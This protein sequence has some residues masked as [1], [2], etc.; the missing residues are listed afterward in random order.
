MKKIKTKYRRMV[1][2]IP[3]PDSIAFF[4]SL[5]AK[6]CRSTHEQPPVIWDKAYG[7]QVFDPFGNIFLDF[8]SGVL[9]ANCGHS[10]P[11]VVRAIRREVDRGL[12]HSYCFANAARERLLRKLREISPPELSR[13]YLLSTGSETIET[14]IKLCRQWG[15]AKSNN[16]KIKIIS[17]ENNFHGRTLGAQQSGGIKPL[18]DWIV[19]LDK[20]FIQVPFPDGI[21]CTDT[22]FDV[23]LTSLQ[24]KGVDPADVAGVLVETY[25]GGIVSFA[26]KEYMQA[27]RNWCNKH[28]ILLLFDEVQAGFGRTGKWWGFQH[29]EIVP[30][31][32]ACGKGI[33]G[34]LP[35]SAVIGRNTIMQQFDAGAMTTT[36]GGN[37]ICCAAAAASIEVL[38]KEKLVKNAQTMGKLLARELDKIFV[39]ASDRIRAVCSHG[40]VAGIHIKKENSDEPDGELAKKIV[41]ECV[42]NGLLMFAP[43]GPGGATLKICPP[44]CI[45]KPA[46]R[47]G[48]K[49]IREAI[50]G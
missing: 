32:I 26:P 19:N 3:H 22:S 30:D 34:G 1:S 20:D 21:Y 7:F 14:L 29:Y 4:D 16:R 46:L 24:S 10:H 42:Q 49:V 38:Q 13:Y 50:G 48:L 37:P 9:V 12:L 43:V 6:E 44:L 27:L 41:N 23:F 35:V 39:L 17:F 33:S 5:Y 28:D 47:E 8:S 18:K 11:K 31:L 25:Q 2:P 15:R 36:H 40:L 45:N